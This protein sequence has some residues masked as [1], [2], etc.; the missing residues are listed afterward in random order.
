MFRQ[1][2]STML[3]FR[4]AV[5]TFHL[6]QVMRVKLQPPTSMELGAFNPIS[7]PPSISQIMLLANPTKVGTEHEVV[8]RL[9]LTATSSIHN[10][11]DIWFDAQG[12]TCITL[13]AREKVYLI[14]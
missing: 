6:P 3:M 5:V 11:C 2:T 1:S 7:P 12:C 10:F 4:A 13:L 8:N 9:L 14:G